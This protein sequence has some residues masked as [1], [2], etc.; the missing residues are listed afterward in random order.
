LTVHIPKGAR[1]VNHLGLDLEQNGKIL[2]ETTHPQVKQIV[3]YVRFAV[4]G[5]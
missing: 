4:Q 5:E 3:L 1:P 2:V